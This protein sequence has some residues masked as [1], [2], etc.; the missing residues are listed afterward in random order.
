MLI[1]SGRVDE[2]EAEDEFVAAATDEDTKVVVVE[3]CEIDVEEI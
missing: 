2:A 3:G 1:T